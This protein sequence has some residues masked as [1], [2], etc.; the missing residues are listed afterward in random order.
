VG[1]RDVG[2]QFGVSGETVRRCL[3]ENSRI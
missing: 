1:M 2:K 3:S